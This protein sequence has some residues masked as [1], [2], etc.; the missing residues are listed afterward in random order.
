MVINGLARKAP[1]QFFLRHESTLTQVLSWLYYENHFKVSIFSNN[2]SSW[3][4]FKQKSDT[5]TDFCVENLVTPWSKLDNEENV[6][7]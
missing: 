7:L 5:G 4:I 6:F 1:L 2:Q 3:R